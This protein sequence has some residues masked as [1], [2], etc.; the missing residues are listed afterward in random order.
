MP[1]KEAEE[2]ALKHLERVQ[3]LDQAQKYPGQL[4][5]RSTTKSSYS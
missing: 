4:I 1:K 2:L 5:W 3:I